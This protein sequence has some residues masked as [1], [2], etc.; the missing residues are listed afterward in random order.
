M[1]CMVKACENDAFVMYGSNWV[2]GKCCVKL[3][4]KESE[5]R[6]RRVEELEI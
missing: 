1:K 6:R 4:E 3:I 5:E 2:C